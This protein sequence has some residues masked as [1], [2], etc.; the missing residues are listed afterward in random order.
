MEVDTAEEV[1]LHVLNEDRQGNVFVLFP[2]PGLDLGNPLPTGHHRLPGRLRGVPQD[3]EV[4]SAGGTEVFLV[5]AS[6]SP[7]P[8]IQLQL[9][10]VPAA[11]EEA[12]RGA[13]DDA[14]RGV[15][16]LRRA[17]PVAAGDSQLE[18]I[19]RAMSGRQEHDGSVW[20]RRYELVNPIR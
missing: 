17:P 14:L 13:A 2:I 15:G 19:H 16:G 10:E 3:W 8:D 9:A 5:I 1:F 7:L 20:V 18:S 4:T 11:S 12:S 6:R